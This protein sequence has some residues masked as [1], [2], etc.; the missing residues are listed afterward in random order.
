MP[1]SYALRALVLSPRDGFTPAMPLF[2]RPPADA[3]FCHASF[4]AP[5]LMPLHCLFLCAD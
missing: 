3:V 4:F 2:M 1:E 5:A